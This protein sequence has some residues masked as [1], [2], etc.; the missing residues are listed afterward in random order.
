MHK[1]LGS[2]AVLL[3]FPIALLSSGCT[4]TE[5]VVSNT[6]PYEAQQRINTSEEF[7]VDLEF[8]SHPDAETITASFA[9]AESSY[10]INRPFA[11]KL[12]Q[13]FRSKF[14]EISEESENKV[15]VEISDVNTNSETGPLRHRLSMSVDVTVEQDGEENSRIFEFRTTIRPED[16]GTQYTVAYR[17]PPEPIEEFLMQYVVGIDSF[18]DSN[19]GIEG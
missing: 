15:T 11:G 16:E 8:K 12:E 5:T 10:S 17:I 18:L 7:D 13:L 19:L 1:E 9:G 3:L 6:L 14:G 4:S 2:V